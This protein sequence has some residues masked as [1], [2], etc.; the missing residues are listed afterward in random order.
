MKPKYVYHGSPNGNIKIFEPRNPNDVG[1]SK[2]NL[3]KGVYATKLKKWA[4]ILGIL[5][6]KG[7]KCSR[8][9][10]ES[11]RIEGIIFGGKSTQK[12]FYVYTFDSDKFRNIPVNSHQYI[13]REEIKPLKVEKFLVKDYLKWIRYANDREIKNLRNMVGDKKMKEILG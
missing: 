9:N 13:C 4:M 2:H 7:I 8:I 3:H 1:R 10:I 12:Y 5:A 11:K 6:G